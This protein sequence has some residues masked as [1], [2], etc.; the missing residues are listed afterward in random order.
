MAW[1][2]GDFSPNL[3]P[4]YFCPL[5]TI[6]AFSLKLVSRRDCYTRLC[7][8]I[9]LL[10]ISKFSVRPRGGSPIFRHKY[11]PWSIP[12]TI[13][14][15][16]MVTKRSPIISNAK[17]G[18]EGLALS[19]PACDQNGFEVTYKACL[20]VVSRVALFDRAYQPPRI[21]I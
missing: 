5:G 7:T 10:L 4:I 14:F 3:A 20:G 19:C 15:P 16:P 17:T 8:E 9:N 11:G 12:R 2:L 1:K 18:P 13:A 6:L 21:H